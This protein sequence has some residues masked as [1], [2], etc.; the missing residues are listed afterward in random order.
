MPFGQLELTNWSITPA[1]P[2]PAITELLIR[3]TGVLPKS[4]NSGFIRRTELNLEGLHQIIGDSRRR[5]SLCGLEL[6]RPGTAALRSEIWATRS[7][8]GR[9]AESQSLRIKPTT[10]ALTVPA[11]TEFLIRLI[12]ELHKSWSSGLFPEDAIK[13]RRSA[14]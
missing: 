8:V 6:L 10:P 4:R 14:S 2:A 3:L 1:L 5:T 9:Y 11:I 12:G 7:D 13:F